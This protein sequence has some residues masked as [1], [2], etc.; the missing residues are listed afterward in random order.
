VSEVLSKPRATGTLFSVVIP[1]HDA[2]GVIGRCLQSFLPGFGPGEVQVVVVAYDCVDATAHI[3]AGFAGVTVVELEQA[4]RSDAINAGETAV[5][6]FP[7]LYLDPTCRVS[8]DDLRL[9]AE[10]VD[11]AEARAVVPSG[12]DAP[13]SG[14]RTL[15]SYEGM[16]VRVPHPRRS[17]DGVYGLSSTARERFTVFPSDQDDRAFLHQNLTLADHGGRPAVSRVTIDGVPFD[18]VTEEQAV[19]RVFDDLAMNEGGLLL[20]PNVDIV[21]QLRE[22]GNA[23]LTGH[24]TLIVADGT[25][26]VWAS[27]ILGDPL[28]A[29]VTGSSLIWSLSGAAASSGHRVMLLG[30]AE[31]VAERA[32]HRLERHHPDLAGVQWHY[33]PF[34]FDADENGFS[35]VCDAVEQARPDVVFVGLGFPRQERLALRLLERFPST[36]FVGCGGGITMT[37]GD[38]SR[39][40]AWMQ[41]CGLEWI[42]RLSQEPKRLFRRYL[43]DDAPYALGMLWR[44][45]TR[46]VRSWPTPLRSY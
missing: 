33:P 42:F 24:A 29:R 20:T 32:A 2:A 35:D 11:V 9:L 15:E 43:V 38:V 10:A 44:T 4:T 30:G 21:R 26:I 22:P 8:A 31:G 27:S 14:R 12:L 25:P 46:R 23:D 5:D 36:W 16:Q 39:A 41:R 40:P 6:A 34:G 7:R 18:R 45:A 37:A 17:A 28:P 19:V 13:G 1:A 3:A